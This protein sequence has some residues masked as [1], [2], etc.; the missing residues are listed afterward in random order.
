MANATTSKKA[1]REALIQFLV[2][3]SGAMK[4]AYCFTIQGRHNEMSLSTLMFLTPEE[5]AAALL[6]AGLVHVTAV[7]Q[8]WCKK[9]IWNEFV[10]EAPNFD[11]VE[12]RK[13][14]IEITKSKINTNAFVRRLT[15]S[16]NV[17]DVTINMKLDILRVGMLS[18]GEMVKTSLQY[19][20]GVCPPSRFL[21]RSPQSDLKDAVGEPPPMAVAYSSTP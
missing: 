12:R 11:S 7:G 8:I 20:D 16:G 13:N 3:A 17:P 14:C 1:V 15:K 9:D 6:T 10:A 5:Y 19:C 18:K 2:N 4:E 21:L